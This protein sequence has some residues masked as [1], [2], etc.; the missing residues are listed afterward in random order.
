MMDSKDNVATVLEE[1]EVGDRVAVRLGQ[2]TRMLVAKERIPFGFKI[3]L[4][5]IPRGDPIVKYGEV[6][7]GAGVPIEEGRLVHVHNLE[8]TRGRGDLEKGQED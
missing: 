5:S 4:T 1:V 2:G 3:A 6:I 8:G 7:G